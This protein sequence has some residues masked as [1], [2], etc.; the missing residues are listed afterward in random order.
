MNDHV[1]R[2]A[3][4]SPN[5][6]Q[7]SLEWA[8]SSGLSLLEKE[9]LHAVPVDIV[10]RNLGYKDANNGKARR[11]LAN[12]KAFG[13]LDK[14]SGGKLAVSQDVQRFKLAPSDADKIN[15]LKQW[16]IKPALYSKLLE[17]YPGELPSDGALV[18]ELVNEHGFNE[19]AARKAIEVFRES[20]RFVESKSG[21]ITNEDG[22]DDIEEE[23]EEPES[24]NSNVENKKE[25]APVVAPNLNNTPPPPPTPTSGN[26]RYPIRLA[27]GRMAYIDVP[28][29]FYE[30]DKDKL[31]AQLEI[32]GTVDEDNDFGDFDM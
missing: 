17:K 27:G 12:L 19:D 2:R 8:V 6:P 28:D 30:K 10:A 1:R 9:N 24:P 11:V 22:D 18:F 15:Y 3:P 20:I 14:A 13:I 5:Y 16:V 29:P 26:V 4:R 31:K 32:I 25:T 7:Q 21:H 23:E